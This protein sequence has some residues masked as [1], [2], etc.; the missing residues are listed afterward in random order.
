MLSCERNGFAS[1][2]DERSGHGT[3]LK[4][5]SGDQAMGIEQDG[6]G[7]ISEITYRDAYPRNVLESA[8]PNQLRNSV[9]L[10]VDDIKQQPVDATLRL[11]ALACAVD[12]LCFGVIAFDRACRI[13]DVNGAALDLL[14]GEGTGISRT[15]DGA[16]SLH[17]PAGLELQRRMADRSP[18]AWADSLMRIP[19]T[20]GQAGMCGVL[21]AVPPNAAGAK[22][23]SSAWVLF[24][25]DPTTVRGLSAAIIAS[26]L[27]ITYREAQIA[28][29]LAAGNDLRATAQQMGI[30]V[31][32]A[33]SHLRSMFE[34]LGVRSQG[35]L[36]R[37]I[38]AG[39]ANFLIDRSRRPN[40]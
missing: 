1:R 26:D 3:S 23:E 31:H 24:L 18:K 14:S 30:K 13:L 17:E 6:V 35:N 34:K 8:V 5:F 9:H 29:L 40:R 38:L 28:S 19:R 39:P 20:D 27:R 11:S 32:T 36:L 21:V 12:H 2:H 25:F 7:R 15:A 33:R 4:K 37:R 16:L 22:L 10:W